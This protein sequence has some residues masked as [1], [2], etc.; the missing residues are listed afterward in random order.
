[1]A[2][3]KKAK[4]PTRPSRQPVPFS[5]L[6]IQ[7][8]RERGVSDEQI[9]QA[10][11]RHTSWQ[12]Q[13]IANDERRLAL[14]RRSEEAQPWD[15]RPTGSVDEVAVRMGSGKHMDY[16]KRNRL[17]CPLD[18]YLHRNL[19]DD[20]QAAGGALFRQRWEMARDLPSS[21]TANYG[22]VTLGAREDISEAAVACREHIVLIRK[23]TIDVEFALLVGVCGQG[24]T[25]E[26]VLRQR[27]HPNAKNH[28]IPI[29][30][31][32]LDAVCHIWGLTRETN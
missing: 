21:V 10:Q 17:E 28:A 24:E 2:R 19:I 27:Q 4:R 26:F 13:Q 22:K 8:A 9:D 12:R 23:R 29:L 31:E 16:A 20:E 32:A 7:G 11:E 18:S 3:T 25:A 1:M 30:R 15:Y 6:T 14:I 5:S